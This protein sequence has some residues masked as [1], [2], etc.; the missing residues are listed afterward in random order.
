MW[1]TVAAAIVELIAF[2]MYANSTASDGDRLDGGWNPPKV[3]YGWRQVP[4]VRSLSIDG[5]I[6]DTIAG[7]PVLCT[8]RHPD[9][10]GRWVCTEYT[11]VHQRHVVV[12]SPSSPLHFVDCNV[13]QTM[14]CPDARDTEV[15]AV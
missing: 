9:E 8:N 6:G 7:E 1:G 2:G 14:P 5:Q 3:L 11:Y 4:P 12:M 13:H 10:L 15:A